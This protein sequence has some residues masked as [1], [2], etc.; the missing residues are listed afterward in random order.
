MN[1]WKKM[2]VV[3]RRMVL[4]L[5]L[6]FWQGGFT[7]YG[8]VVVPIGGAVL[9][10]DTEQGFITQAVTNYLN[11]AG[12]VCLLFW[13]EHLWHERKNGVFK[14]EWLLWAFSVL[15]LVV[16]AVT[17]IQMDKTIDHNSISVL[18]P[19]SFDIYHKIYIGT[20]SL[21]WAGTICLLFMA[22]FRWHRQ[23]GQIR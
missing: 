2:I 14:M 13:I 12:A 20:S 19:K 11:L 18:N 16:L 22:M 9:G 4:I 5:S 3:I 8:G 10:S 7:F 21:Q 6:M 17:H 15:T 23:D 1:G